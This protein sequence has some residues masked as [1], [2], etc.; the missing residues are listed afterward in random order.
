MESS[1]ATSHPR[2]AAGS[3][4][5]RTPLSQAGARGAVLARLLVWG[6]FLAAAISACVADL[7][8]GPAGAGSIVFVAAAAL[9]WPLTAFSIGLYRGDQLSAWASAVPDV[10]RTFVA[11][12]ILS[13]PLLAVGSALGASDAAILTLI[14][15]VGTAGL[16]A[17]SR[18][19]VRAR[20]HKSDELIQRTLIIG[21]GVVAGQVV[22]KL[23][24]NRQFG[25]VPIGIVD[26][27]VHLVGLPDMPWL[28]RLSDLTKVIEKEHP[29]RV[30]IAFSK[31]SHEELLECIRAC[32]DAG[33]A[34]DVVP[35]LFEFLDG[36]RAL[37]Q[38]GGLPLLSIGRPT[39]SSASMTAKRVLDAVGALALLILFSPLMLA[40]AVAIKLESRGPVFFRQPRAGR[41]GTSFRLIK[42][43]SMYMDAEKR[44]AALVELN[45]S[46]DGVMFKIKDDPRVTRVGRVLRRLSL[47]EL[48]Q[49]FNVLV[50]EMSLVGPR[51]LIF[52]ESD[53]LDAKWHLRRL[54]LRPGLTGPWQVYGR[55]QNPFQEMVR[56]DY[57]Y[58]AGWSLARDIELLL[59]TIPA[60]LS[61][62]GA[63]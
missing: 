2:R 32:R 44:K 43:R 38:V 34:I 3:A 9:L 10:P 11:L 30:I 5:E 62:R 37:D 20:L 28:G 57:Q 22:E 8:A 48:P 46:S 54:E 49:L 4:V 53:A 7:V 55:S 26:D 58:V 18:S 14:T 31:A 59:A 51:P 42:F 56:F 33:V 40:I 50:G 47:D 21:S 60:V 23:E 52:S 24:N 16:S 35:R 12:L 45:E 6:D 41:G 63:Y 61:G 29:D 15:I 1:T 13:W 39:L 25:L 36:V 27:D 19:G 17:F